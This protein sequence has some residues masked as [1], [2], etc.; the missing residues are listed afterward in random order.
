MELIVLI[1]ILFVLVMFSAFYAAS[2]IA[3]VSLPE[4]TLA[5]L[6]KK[7][8]KVA[9]ALEYHRDNPQ[10]FVI[11]ISI[12]NNF[13]NIFA[14]SLATASMVALFPQHGVLIA[15][16]GMTFLI[17]MFG[18]IIPKVFAI[19]K[20]EFIATKS[21]FPLLWSARVLKPLIYLFSLVC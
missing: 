3:I 7:H 16:V 8:P 20:T 13:I 2:E 1:I 19:N 4:A 18:E 14:S 17:L 5:E 12:A 10:R 11:N 21:A 9:K 6:R 15:T